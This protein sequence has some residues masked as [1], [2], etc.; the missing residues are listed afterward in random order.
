[1]ERTYLIYYNVKNGETAKTVV[2]AKSTF[3]AVN[4]FYSDWLDGYN[5]SVADGENLICSPDELE[6]I[7]AEPLCIASDVVGR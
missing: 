2:F 5:K 1:M 4:K 7:T 6:R 3:E